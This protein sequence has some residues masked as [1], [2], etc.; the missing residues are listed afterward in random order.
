[1]PRKKPGDA[2]KKRG[3]PAKEAPVVK[4]KGGRPRKV[5]EE[6]APKVVTSQPIETSRQPGGSSAFR[7][8]DARLRSMEAKW[9]VSRGRDSDWADGSESMTDEE[10]RD[11]LSAGRSNPESTTD[12]V[13]RALGESAGRGS[14]PVAPASD[15][16]APSRVGPGVPDFE[17]ARN[18]AKPT[19]GSGATERGVITPSRFT[20]SPAVEIAPGVP[21]PAGPQVAWTQAVIGNRPVSGTQHNVIPRTRVDPVQRRL[22]DA[23]IFQRGINLHRAITGVMEGARTTYRPSKAW[24]YKNTPEQ[25]AREKAHV[26]DIKE[27]TGK[28]E[29]RVDMAIMHP[30]TE[31]VDYKKER[32][33]PHDVAAWQEHVADVPREKQINPSG[34]TVADTTTRYNMYRDVFRN[35]RKKAEGAYDNPEEGL[36]SDLDWGHW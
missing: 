8:A 26:A 30:R 1:M 10:F 5:V 13:S 27:R 25:A 33:N 31:G 18:P 35:P 32:P 20:V 16:P 2:P 4:N 34:Q 29:S 23:E 11:M 22:E 21:H 14:R 7:V 24:G 17:V 15:R 28:V 9:G 19:P 6:G 12:A 36:P 3:R